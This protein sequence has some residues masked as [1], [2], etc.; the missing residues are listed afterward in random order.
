[1]A[2]FLS[3]NAM[4]KPISFLLESIISSIVYFFVSILRSKVFIFSSALRV[5]IWSISAKKGIIPTAKDRIFFGLKLHISGS[6]VYSFFLV[7]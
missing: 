4:P 3:Y 7:N 6:A 2:K 1:V 5:K